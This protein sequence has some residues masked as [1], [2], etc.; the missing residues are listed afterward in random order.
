MKEEISI[1]KANFK[2]FY[3]I[4]CKLTDTS[5]GI[6]SKCQ[7]K[8]TEKT[9]AVKLYDGYFEES[10]NKDILNE[11]LHLSKYEHP[12]LMNYKEIY[13]FNNQLA[14]MMEYFEGF[15][16]YY[17]KKKKKKKTKKKNN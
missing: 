15:K 4:Y 14:I 10:E 16:K 7:E 12:N 17:K 1:L 6:I 13:L 2:E 8:K 11:L 9:Y 5:F 3:Q